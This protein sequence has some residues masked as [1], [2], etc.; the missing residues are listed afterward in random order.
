MKGGTGIPY[1]LMR[2]YLKLK[3][4][5]TSFHIENKQ[6]TSFSCL[7]LLLRANR[8]EKNDSTPLKF[9]SIFQMGVVIFGLFASLIKRLA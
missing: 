2:L 8:L 6:T 3:D 7:V 5:L 9:N 4:K 1:R